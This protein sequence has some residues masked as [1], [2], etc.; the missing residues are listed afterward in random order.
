MAARV[1]DP[2]RAVRAARRTVDSLANVVGTVMNRGDERSPAM[3]FTGPR[4]RFTG[5]L[6]ADRAVAFGRAP[7]ED[8]KVVKNVYG[9]KLNDVV[10]ATCS[11]ALRKYHEGH[12]EIPDKPLLIMCPVSTHT[13]DGEGTNQVSSMAVRLPVHMADPVDQLLEIFEDTKVAKEMQSALGAEMLSDITQFAPPVLF[14]QAMRLYTRSGLADRHVPVQ[15]GVI[16]NIPGPPIPMWVV[17][18]PVLAVYPL[19]PAHR[20]GGA[21]HHRHLQHGPDGHRDRGRPSPGPRHL[22]AG[23]ALGGSGGRAPRSGRS[24]SRSRVRLTPFSATTHHNRGGRLSPETLGQAVMPKRCEAVGLDG[25]AAQDAVAL[26]GVHARRPRTARGRPCGS[27]GTCRRSAGSRS[28]T[29]SG[30]G[31]RRRG[32]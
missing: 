17:G 21:E 12:G 8:L 5:S 18:A 4:T 27:A 31:R 22:V 11:M 14:N 6:S 9:C 1:K 2:W 10:L 15:N 16:S 24:R 13:P 23:R 29:G 19:G 7:L 25:V 28:R 20:R 32:T 30:R 3:P 26:V